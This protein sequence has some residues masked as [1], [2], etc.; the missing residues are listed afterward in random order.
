[1]KFQFSM[2][3]VIESSQKKVLVV[4]IVILLLATLGRDLSII[5][6]PEIP[7]SFSL[8]IIHVLTLTEIILVI[9]VY[10]SKNSYLL[11]QLAII[12]LLVLYA[13]FVFEF[14]VNPLVFAIMIPALF[15]SVMMI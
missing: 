15:I 2:E 3:K 6:K 1:M 14:R 8:M 10:R 9:L 5:L 12:N 13:L 4:G 11:R 7:F